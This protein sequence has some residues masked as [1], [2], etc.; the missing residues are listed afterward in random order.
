MMLVRCFLPRAWPPLYRDQAVKLGEPHRPLCQRP[1]HPCPCR[2]FI[3]AA[4]AGAMRQPFVRD[5][6]QNGKLARGEA[7]RERRRQWP[8]RRMLDAGAGWKSACQATAGRRIAE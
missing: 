3:E 6:L 1:A 8:G 4:I 5:H 7:C 2:Q